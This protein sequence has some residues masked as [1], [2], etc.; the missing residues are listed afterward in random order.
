MIINFAVFKQR[1][2]YNSLDLFLT[3]LLQNNDS[4]TH[5]FCTENR[6]SQVKTLLTWRVV[7]EKV[8]WGLFLLFGGGFALAEGCKVSTS[9]LSNLTNFK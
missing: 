4:M 1:M 6:P 3:R 7:H 5:R 9:W 2:Q 8:P